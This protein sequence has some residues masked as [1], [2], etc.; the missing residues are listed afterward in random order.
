MV[1]ILCPFIS[2]CQDRHHLTICLLIWLLLFK[3]IKMP[4]KPIKWRLYDWVTK[5]KSETIVTAT[6]FLRLSCFRYNSLQN[7]THCNS[8]SWSEFTRENIPAI[9]C[10]TAAALASVGLTT[11][12]FGHQTVLKVSSRSRNGC[13]RQAVLSLWPYHHLNYNFYDPHNHIVKTRLK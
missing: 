5:K 6:E 11:K 2:D 4:F 13:F 12:R 1:K 3:Q 8:S 9:N 10:S 7:S